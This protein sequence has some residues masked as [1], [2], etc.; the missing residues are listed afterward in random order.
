VGAARTGFA[1]SAV[2]VV[3]DSYAALLFC[4]VGRVDLERDLGVSGIGDTLLCLDLGVIG[5]H[6]GGLL[7]RVGLRGFQITFAHGD[8]SSVRDS[9]T[10]QSVMTGRNAVKSVGLM[11][12]LGCCA[13]WWGHRPCETPDVTIRDNRQLVAALLDVA[14]VSGASIE[15]TGAGP[16]TLRLQLAAGT[17]QVIVAGE[18]NRLL[19][20]KFGLAV[21][22]DR[23]RVIDE[24]Y[25]DAGKHSVNAAAGQVDDGDA[26]RKTVVAPRVGPPAVGAYARDAVGMATILSTDLRIANGV[27]HIA[28][29]DV[30][31]A[32]PSR[33]SIERVQ[34]VSAG[35]GTAVTVTLALDGRT[36][37]G[38]AE[39]AATQTGLLRS[40]AA[41]TLRAV[42]QITDGTVRF[43][44]EHVEIARAG[45]DQTALVVVTMLTGRSTERLSGASVVRE[46][47]REAVI[48]AV[49]AALN[50]RMEPLLADQ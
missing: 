12:E 25:A 44:V 6:L 24:T 5:N 13:V 19:R 29:P 14:G 11:G 4:P 49:L 45:T 50:R 38:E 41:A 48:R 9:A 33:L 40:V 46:D 20:S 18:V 23:V 37:D 34:L 17:D 26:G 21:D 10:L 43:E 28:V 22:P 31:L 36:L 1:R 15:A 16:G 27:D 7:D 35:L 30:T 2:V 3:G 39:G 42:E 8:G 32:R 47:T